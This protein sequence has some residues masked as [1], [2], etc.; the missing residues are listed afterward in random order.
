MPCQFQLDQFTSNK[1]KK[2]VER[3]EIYQPWS[4]YSCTD[5]EMYCAPILAKQ[6]GSFSENIDFIRPPV[7]HFGTEK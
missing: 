6:E 3:V 7:A 1:T 4:V 5:G 2:L